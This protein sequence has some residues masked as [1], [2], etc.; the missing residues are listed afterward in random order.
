MLSGYDAAVSTLSEFLDELV[1]RVDNEGRVQSGETVPLQ[2]LHDMDGDK[3]GGMKQGTKDSSIV[4]PGD[5]APQGIGFDDYRSRSNT[6]LSTAR[7]PV[8]Y[9]MKSPP[10]PMTR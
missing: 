6:I 2:C 9:C 1:L 4:E 3:D 8:L 10:S 5:G 7:Y